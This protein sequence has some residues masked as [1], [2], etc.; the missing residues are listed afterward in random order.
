MRKLYQIVGLRD[1]G[2]LIEELCRGLV[3]ETSDDVISKSDNN[4]R[5]ETGGNQIIIY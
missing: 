1:T 4:I 3:M 5:F 2:V